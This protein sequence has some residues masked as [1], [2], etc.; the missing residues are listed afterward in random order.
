M[1]DYTPVLKE[2]ATAVK[3]IAGAP[4]YEWVMP[5]VVL[6]SAGIGY[7]ASQRSIAKQNERQHTI[8]RERKKLVFHLLHHEI[9]KRWKDGIRPY[10]LGLLKMNPVEGLGHLATTEIHREDLLVLKLLSE[11]FSELHFIG[12]HG[13][14]SEIVHGHIL[15]GDLVDVRNHV[16]LV[17][18]ERR[19]MREQL[20]TSLSEKEVSQKLEENF[21]PAIQS[22]WNEFSEKLKAIDERFDDLL[23]K[24]ENETSTSASQN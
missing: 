13:L 18:N 5:I 21:S 24:L 8:D 1:P 7:W 20:G 10:L 3:T 9:T 16:A 14:I 6:L 4:N 22:L 23:P 2:I 12:D 17:M 19:A 11:S 15:M